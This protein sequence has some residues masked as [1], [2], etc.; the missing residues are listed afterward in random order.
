M[1]DLDELL[2]RV[3]AATGPDRELDMLL[4]DKFGIIAE[5]FAEEGLRFDPN[6][7]DVGVP[8]FLDAGT[9]GGMGFLWHAPPYTASIDAAVSLVEVRR[10]VMRWGVSCHSFK[11]GETYPDGKPKY[12]DGFRA[13]VSERSVLRPIP[14]VADAPTAPLTILA[15]LLQALIGA[16]E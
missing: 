13:H 1:T 11:G 8:Y 2:V 7:V 5:A 15:A 12:V 4:S 3:K 14:S 10:P 16:K 6:Q 9:C